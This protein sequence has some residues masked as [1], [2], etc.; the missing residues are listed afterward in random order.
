MYF[1]AL[2]YGSRL[3]VIDVAKIL[4]QSFKLQLQ[5]LT[6][7]LG[8]HKTIHFAVPGVWVMFILVLVK[9]L[10]FG[11]YSIAAKN[12]PHGCPLSVG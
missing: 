6:L 8:I 7:R 11:R 5:G 9:I 12:R 2:C 3:S 4:S 10:G 1:V